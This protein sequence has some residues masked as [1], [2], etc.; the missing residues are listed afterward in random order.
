[1]DTDSISNKLKHVTCICDSCSRSELFE[2]FR[3][4]QIICYANAEL[5]IN[6]ILIS[7]LCLKS[8]N[9]TGNFN[10]API[11]DIL[12]NV[13]FNSGDKV[14]SKQEDLVYLGEEEYYYDLNETAFFENKNKLTPR[15]P[16]LIR[17]ILD[18]CKKRK[19]KLFDPEKGIEI[20]YA[21]LK[22]W[23]LEKI[24]IVIYDPDG[25][26]MGGSKT[27]Y[28]MPERNFDSLNRLRIK[29][30]L[31][32]DMKNEVLISNV[33]TVDILEPVITQS[34]IYMGNAARFRFYPKNK[35]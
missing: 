17:L 15:A 2:I 3:V 28:V 11:W 25:V 12:F 26:G 4:K 20:A 33:K 30:D 29:Q 21:K 31:F 19:L 9:Y 16:T 14:N 1:M 24:P 22:S 6:N 7:P 5:S 32:F 10:P 35:R 8:N 23:G 34:G 13:A 27:R 18:D